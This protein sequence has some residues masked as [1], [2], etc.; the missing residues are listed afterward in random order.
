[1]TREELKKANELASQIDKF[2]EFYNAMY[3]THDRTHEITIK[4]DN[5][6]TPSFFL[7][8]KM[9]LDIREGF[10]STLQPQLRNWLN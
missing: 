8:A 6:K 9:A 4:V 3:P 7:P 10:K 5:Y 1:M 2:T